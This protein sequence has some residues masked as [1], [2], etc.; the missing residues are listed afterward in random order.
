VVSVQLVANRV[1]PLQ[2]TLLDEAA[3][4]AGRAAVG[5]QVT[6]LPV[7]VTSTNGT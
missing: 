3:K 1:T 4:I 5:V 7:P 2:V 6:V